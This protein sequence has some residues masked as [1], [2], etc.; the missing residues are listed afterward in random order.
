[1][2]PYPYVTQKDIGLWSTVWRRPGHWNSRKEKVGNTGEIPKKGSWEKWESGGTAFPWIL[3]QTGLYCWETSE[4]PKTTK[5]QV[6]WPWLW[7]FYPSSGTE[8]WQQGKC[9]QPRLQSE[10]DWGLLHRCHSLGE[11]SV[12]SLSLRSFIWRKAKKTIFLVTWRWEFTVLCWMSLPWS[13]F[14][15]SNNSHWK[16][17]QEKMAFVWVPLVICAFMLLQAP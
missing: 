5:S 7:T 11:N 8:L 10:A 17:M 13:R 9:K 4:M 16:W 12:I 14:S 15:R 3:R 2:A 1:M 6:T